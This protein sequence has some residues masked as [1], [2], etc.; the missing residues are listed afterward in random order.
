ML[1]LDFVDVTVGGETKKGMYF[2]QAGNLIWK[3]HGFGAN[4]WDMAVQFR[5]R[6]I[7]KDVPRRQ[8]IRGDVSVLPF[9]TRCRATCVSSSSGPTCIP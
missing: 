4:P 9:A 8:W 6:L 3:K 7:K 2:Y 5:D 1:T